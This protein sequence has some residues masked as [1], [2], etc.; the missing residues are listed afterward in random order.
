VDKD[1]RSGRGDLCGRSDLSRRDRLVCARTAWLSENDLCG[2][3]D[4]CG[5]ARTAGLLLARI[6]AL[7]KAH[8][9]A[10]IPIS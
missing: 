7:L 4:L 10:V 8:V 6:E 2:R 1:D 9:I 3:G 5:R